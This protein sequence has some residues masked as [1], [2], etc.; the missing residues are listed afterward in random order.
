M[1][2]WIKCEESLPADGESGLCALRHYDK[3][4]GPLIVV[5][6]TFLGDEFHPFADNDGIENDD[7]WVD[8]LYWPT[9]WM[10]LPS[11]P[12]DSQ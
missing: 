4:D 9:H 11:P 2:E 6:F 10:P 12:E 8:P 7:Y 1:I 5:P 3:A